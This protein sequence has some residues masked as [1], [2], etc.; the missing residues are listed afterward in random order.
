MATTGGIA[1]RRVSPFQGARGSIPT[2]P[3]AQ[4]QTPDLSNRGGGGEE[5]PSEGSSVDGESDESDSDD[6]QPK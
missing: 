5:N 2:I 3:T 4:L 6:S 1:T